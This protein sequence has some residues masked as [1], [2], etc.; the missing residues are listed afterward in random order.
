[1]DTPQI[2]VNSKVVPSIIIIIIL[3][4]VYWNPGISFFLK[5]NLRVYTTLS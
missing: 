5:N 4:R 2:I 3:V 1:M